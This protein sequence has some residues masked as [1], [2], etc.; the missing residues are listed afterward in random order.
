M[1]DYS[2][3]KDPKCDTSVIQFRGIYRLIKRN[4]AIIGAANNM[5]K[6]N[7]INVGK[8]NIK[9]ISDCRWT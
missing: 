3:E 6:S 1:L 5:G 2:K 9:A 7:C 8:D 4:E